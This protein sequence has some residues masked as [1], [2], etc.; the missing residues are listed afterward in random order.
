MIARLVIFCL[1]IL[2]L[3]IVFFATGGNIQRPKDIEQGCTI[4]EHPLIYK[5]G[6][7]AETPEEACSNPLFGKYAFIAGALTGSI[8]FMALLA[9]V[10]RAFDP[11]QPY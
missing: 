2:F 11:P 3:F 1:L 9:F 10:F 5:L 8:L 7:G 4:I 6:F